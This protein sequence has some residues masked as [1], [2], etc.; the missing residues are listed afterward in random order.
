MT[1]MEDTDWGVG[2]ENVAGDWPIPPILRIRIELFS[3]RWLVPVTYKHGSE[4]VFACP[5]CPALVLLQE[6]TM[7]I[8]AHASS[9]TVRDE[10]G[11][12]ES[13]KDEPVVLANYK[14]ER[15]Q[16]TR[17]VT[18][19]TK[20][21]YDAAYREFE[22]TGDLTL[23]PGM[24]EHVRA[25]AALVQADMDDYLRERD[26]GPAPPAEKPELSIPLWLKLYVCILITEVILLLV[27]IFAI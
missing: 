11:F 22:R 24:T 12:W 15:E 10:L 6:A 1:L 25:P 14:A 8:G 16:E 4:G 7:H 27:M 13:V 20:K 17:D 5:V 3:R 23:L 21:L 26:S 19:I 2:L 9:R 18:G